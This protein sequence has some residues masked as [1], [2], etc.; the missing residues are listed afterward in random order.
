ML[1]LSEFPSRLTL[2]LSY[3][4]A[5]RRAFLRRTGGGEI[6]LAAV[7]AVW[8]RRPQNFRLPA[9]LRD[10][11]Q[12]RFVNSEAATAFQGMYQ[13]LDAFWINEPA[14]DLVATHKPFQ[15]A[16]A[17]AVGL[18]IPD[19]LMTNDPD[20]ARAFWSAHPGEVVYKQFVA[21]PDTWRETRRLGKAEEA[22]AESI[23]LTPVIFQRNVPAVADLRVIVIGA[24]V[25][26]AAADVR[27]GEYP[28]DVRMNLDARY[29]AH[30]LPQPVVERLHRLMDRLG[31]VYGAIDFRLTPDGQYVFL[32]INPAGQFLYIEQQTGQKIA[33]A[34]AEKLVEGA[35]SVSDG[36]R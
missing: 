20:E 12:R 25:F 7:R 35:R 28:Q 21:L 15:L 32:E 6:D 2:S 5:A 19:T 1:D 8:W 10:P 9:T 18:D 16:L 14:R 26:A 36:L 34:L 33:A 29:E 30:D 13:S 22:V 23:R 24:S 11:A 27:G 3:Q 17:Q 31:L 4:G